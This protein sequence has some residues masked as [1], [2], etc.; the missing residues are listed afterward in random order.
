MASSS[1]L[2]AQ[3]LD[4][5]SSQQ[6]V[7]YDSEEDVKFNDSLSNV[8]L[9]DG[10][11]VVPTSKIDKLKNVV[12]KHCLTATKETVESEYIEMPVGADKNTKG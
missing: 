10:L 4:E 7:F 9:I 12:A 8:V 2:V 3:A 1:A 6:E 11:P 5:S